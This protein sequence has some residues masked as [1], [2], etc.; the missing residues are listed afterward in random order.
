MVFEYEKKID[1]VLIYFSGSGIKNVALLKKIEILTALNLVKEYKLF[2]QLGSQVKMPHLDSVVECATSDSLCAPPILLSWPAEEVGN[3]RNDKLAVSDMNA[4]ISLNGADG[5]T[6]IE[7]LNGDGL[8]DVLMSLYA[9]NGWYGN[10]YFQR[11]YMNTGNGFTRNDAWAIP[12][13]Y[14]YISLNGADGG[15]RVADLNGD[16]LPDILMSL[17]ASNGWYGNGSFQRA[18]MNTGSGFVRNDTW[19]LPDAAAHFSLDGADGGTRIVDLNG[20]GL[21]D[22]L[23]SLHASNG[24]YGNGSFQRAY[25]NTGSGF[26]RNDTWALPDAAAHFSLDGADGGTR[27][28]D[29][30]GDGLPDVLM[31]LYAHNG[32]YGN[33]YFQR[34]YMNTGNGFTRN[35]AW[36]IPDGYAYISLNGADGG[37]RVADLN[38]DGLPD[39]LMSLHASNG[40]YGNGSFQRAYMNT[41][42]GFVRNDTWALPDAAAHFSLD[43]AD[44]GTRIIDLNGDGLPDVLM[45]LY[46]HNGWYGNGYF[47]RAYMNTGNGFTRNDAWAISDT[48]TYISLN[49]ADGGVRIA[50]LNGDGS[51]DF[52]MSL[53]ASNGWYGNGHF[54]RAYI[55]KTVRR[56]I[57]KMESSRGESAFFKYSSLVN[58]D[59]YVK[60]TSTAFPKQNVRYP[61]SVVSSVSA[62]NGAGSTVTTNYKYGGLKAELGTGRGMLGFRWL[63]ATQAETGI[64]TRTEFK[65]DWPYTGLVSKTQKS[66]AGAGNNGVLSQVDNTYGCTDFVSSTG[67]TTGVGKRYYVYAS[68]STESSWDVNGAA[69]PTIITASQYDIWGNATQVSVSSSDGYSKVTT[70]SFSNDVGSWYLGRL[71]K[72]SVTSV[73]P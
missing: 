40:W 28:I 69:L 2:Y 70:N 49:G 60:D 14:A 21:P 41:G 1:P 11:A 62:S 25:M 32:W 50:D 58:S 66:L 59:V 16:G 29:L 53:F 6:R 61:Q 52:L 48:S 51:P 34:A 19:A 27:I 35:D 15:V 10:G 31:S 9:H 56:E 37:V 73:V 5:G 3:T 39:I 46:A 33:G 47:Q 23:M 38:G 30:N 42:S 36:A 22:I 43:G 67:C 18:Y 68:Q 57:K 44:G 8:P 4:F 72:A 63:E 13:G 65:Q 54:Q 7:D 55:N 45:S 24:W 17:H 71:N 12:D 26:V 64:V 20:D